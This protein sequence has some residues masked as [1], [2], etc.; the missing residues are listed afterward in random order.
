MRYIDFKKK[1]MDFPL[2]FSAR[3]G[4]SGEEEQVFK[5]QLSRWVKSGLI[6]KLRRGIYILN[7]D[8][9]KV[10]PSRCFLANQLY[11]PSYVS[12]EYA[13][14]FYGLIPERVVDITSVTTK[15]TSVFKNEFGTFIYQHIKRDCFNGFSEAKDENNYTFLIARPEK[16]IVD[17]FYF[18][19]QNFKKYDHSIFEESYRFQNFSDL[20]KK[21]IIDFAVRFKNNKLLDVA[22]TFC[23]L[24][25]KG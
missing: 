5:N 13:L 17:F 21:K 6:L 22:R 2:L 4:I 1:F 14:A 3:A 23:E 10:H 15:K 11:F 25:K 16:A 24:I 9:R 7:K 20:S 18:N 12:N 19:L 8:D